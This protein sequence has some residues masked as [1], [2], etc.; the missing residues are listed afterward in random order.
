[1]AV[2]MVASVPRTVACSESEV[3]SGQRSQL[4]RKSLLLGQPCHGAVFL[5]QLELRNRLKKQCA[6]F[7]RRL[8]E[9]GRPGGPRHNTA[10]VCSIFQE[11]RVATGESEAGFELTSEL[12][13]PTSWPLSGHCLLV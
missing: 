4:P 6:S 2:S 10:S 7:P 5:L 1:M 13:L 3:L 12:S 9:R 8:Y 11:S